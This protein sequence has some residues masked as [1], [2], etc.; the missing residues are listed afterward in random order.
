MTMVKGGYLAKLFKFS[1][2]LTEKLYTVWKLKIQEIMQY[3]QFL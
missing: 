1:F 3:C 2:V